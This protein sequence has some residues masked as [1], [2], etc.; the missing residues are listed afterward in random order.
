MDC[1]DEPPSL[2][3]RGQGAQV[4]TVTR[5]QVKVTKYWGTVVGPLQSLREMIDPFP[6]TYDEGSGS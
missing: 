1:E 4:L 6:L 3:H 2:D 5:C